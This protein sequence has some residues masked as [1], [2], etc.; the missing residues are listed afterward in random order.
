MR[1]EKLDHIIVLRISKTMRDKLMSSGDGS[2]L[3]R[4]AIQK[5]FDEVF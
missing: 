2:K 4:T 5:Y 3:A 1:K